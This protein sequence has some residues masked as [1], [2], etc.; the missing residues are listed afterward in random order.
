MPGH[1]QAAAVHNA[2]AGEAV[3][4]VLTPPGIAQLVVP[5]MAAMIKQGSSAL[6]FLPFTWTGSVGVQE[7]ATPP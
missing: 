7:L 3:V 6:R 1:L 4:A 2:A 5:R